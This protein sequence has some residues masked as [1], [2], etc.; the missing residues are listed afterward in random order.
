MWAQRWL[1]RLR[2]WKRVPNQIHSGREAVAPRIGLALGGGFARGLA[3][4]GVLRVF[5]KHGI[6]LHAIA[7]VSSG[8]IVAAAYASGATPED[9]GRAGAAMRFADVAKWQLSLL[10]LAASERME[11]FLKRLLRCAHFEEMTIPLGV[12]ATDLA[13]GKPIEFCG[14][15]EVGPAIRAS[16]SYPGLLQPVRIDGR[17]LVDGGMSVDVPSELVRKM[18]ANY[19]ISVALQIPSTED[20]EPSNMFQVVNRC[21][22]I[23]QTHMEERWRKASDLVLEPDVGGVSWD[24][25]RS[26]E[27]LIEAGENAATAALPKIQS[28]LQTQP[29]AELNKKRRAPAQSPALPAKIN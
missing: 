22:Q 4:V 27:R 29:P 3:H 24:S 7:G 15:G 12:V 19:V 10:G 2:L 18:G 28:L 25:F 17:Y 26:A 5:Q 1:G 13:T 16:C 11:K 8:A 23:M 14:P 6:P 9:I 20:F 21:F